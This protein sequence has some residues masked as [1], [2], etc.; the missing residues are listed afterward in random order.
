MCPGTNVNIPRDYLYRV[1]YYGGLNQKSPEYCF[2]KI[3]NLFTYLLREC[4]ISQIKIFRLCRSVYGTEK[5]KMTYST[6]G[7]QKH[8]S[9]NRN[10]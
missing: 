1:Q 10:K 9:Q 5:R 6:N 4:H 8:F 2:L 7:T 3:G